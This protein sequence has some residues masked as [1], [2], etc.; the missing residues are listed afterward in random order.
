M[1]L[2]STRVGLAVVA[3]TLLTAGCAG[4][5]LPPPAPEAAEAIVPPGLRAFVPAPVLSLLAVDLAQLRRS[6]FAKPLLASAAPVE[7]RHSRGFDEIED[8]DSW[9]FARVRAPG[10]GIATLEL[11]RGRFD[12]GEVMSAFRTRRPAAHEQRFG[13]LGG[14]ADPEGGLAFFEED[15]VALGP[16]WAIEAA[17]RARQQPAGREPWLVEATAASSGLPGGRGGRP[18]VELW[19]R[20]DDSTR[21]QLAEVLGDAEGLQ[22]LTAQLRLGSDVQAVA[23]AATR[24]PG[25][26]RGLAAQ[27]ADQLAVLHGRR[28]VQALGLG[29]VLERAQ[30]QIDGARL[31]LELRISED[32]RETVAER[33]AVLAQA[34]AKARA[35]TAAEP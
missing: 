7:G 3:A 25:Q 31:R 29:P 5:P 9:L 35:K 15:T 26:A 30:V 10:A 21:S 11:G 19:L 24:G 12:R 13:E 18:A 8:V 4:A 6:P 28:S 32:E 33:L 2:M 17:L 27:V 23:V 14:L 16:V 34:L 1:L 20:L 22:W